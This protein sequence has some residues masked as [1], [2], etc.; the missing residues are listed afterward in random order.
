MTN[1]TDIKLEYNYNYNCKFNIALEYNIIKKIL[2]LYLIED[3]KN[4]EYF[5]Y[6]NCFLYKI[7]YNIKNN[8]KLSENN[9][10]FLLD[11]Y[12]SISKYFIDVISITNDDD[13]IYN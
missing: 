9:K 13:C 10:N 8:I 4:I 6:I 12:I 11:I 3:R 2:P 1:I 7:D 5:N